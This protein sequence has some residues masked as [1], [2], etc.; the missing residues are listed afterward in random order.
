MKYN[1]I[2]HIT[3]AC[4]YNCSYCDVIKDG[5]TLSSERKQEILD[6]AERNKNTIGTFKFFGWE[7]LLAY[8]DILFF[9]DHLDFSWRYHIVTNTTLLNDAIGVYFQKYFQTLFFSV[10]TEH[11]FDYDRVTDFMH[12]FDLREKI[13]C[14]L[15]ITPGKERE[16]YEQFLELFRRGF[17]GYN[18]LPVYFTKPWERED[19]KNLSFFMKKILDFSLLDNSVKLYGFQENSGYDNSLINHSLFI[20]TDWYV[21]YSDMVS[22][23]SAESLKEKLR[24]GHISSLSLDSL[25][26]EKLLEQR[27]LISGLE[28]SL[29]SK[30]PWQRELHKMMDYFSVYMNY[31]DQ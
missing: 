25:S 13:F 20:D 7:P 14:N 15:I 4:N 9:C 18:I 16:S 5:K 10:D 21:Y 6:F 24:L 28:E 19:L 3:T 22:T 11:V 8:K 30:V 1:I 26:E 29:Y 27:N 12:R 31:H 2:L 17:R 23:Y